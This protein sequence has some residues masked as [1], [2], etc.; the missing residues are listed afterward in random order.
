METLIKVCF[1][2]ILVVAT[3]EVLWVLLAIAIEFK[4][5]GVFKGLRKIGNE[6]QDKEGVNNVYW[7]EQKENTRNV[8]RR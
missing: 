1:C 7:F 5:I 8:R 2:T 4:R 3:I 6:I